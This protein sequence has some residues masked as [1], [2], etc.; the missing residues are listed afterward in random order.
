MSRFRSPAGRNDR[1]ISILYLCLTILPFF[2]L[3]TTGCTGPEMPQGYALIYGVSDYS[4]QESGS[5]LYLPSLSSTDDDARDITALLEARGWEV[6]LRLDDGTEA[7]TQAASLAQLEADIAALKLL[8]TPKDRFLFYYS[9]HGYSTSSLYSGVTPVEPVETDSLEEWIFLYSTSDYLNGGVW[10]DNTVND[11]GLGTLVASLPNSIKMVILDSCNSGGFVGTEATVDALPE[12]Y[13][14]S[15][16][17]LPAWGSLVRNWLSYPDAVQ[18]DILA[19]QAVVLAASGESE[20]S[21]EWMNQNGIFTSFLLETP[22][23]GDV[24]RDG[25]VTISEA[26]EYCTNRLSAMAGSL[27]TSAYLPH[28]TGSPVDFVLFPAD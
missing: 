27:G 9:G 16:V 17:Y 10:L 23:K 4:A 26:A 28:I 6:Y 2:L 1:R 3:L 15:T 13:T 20:E 19:S 21:L 7:G 22:E 11:D 24:N 14:G 25:W 12:D 18:A 8:M 5:P